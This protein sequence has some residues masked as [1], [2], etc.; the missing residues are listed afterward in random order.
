MEITVSEVAKKWGITR[1]TIYKKIKQ[2]K[3]SQ[4][5]SRKLD[6][7]EVVRVFGEPSVHDTKN[8][9]QRYT[10]ANTQK[11]GVL[12]SENA[13]L[14]ERIKALENAISDK[15]EALRKSEERE[16]NHFEQMKNLIEQIKLLQ[17]PTVA[18]KPQET[19]KK[20]FFGLFSR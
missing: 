13:V 20:G 6:V 3:I 9:D 16:Q 2:N 12:A 10:G 19:R 15:K 17:S 1:T 7:A 5:P 4:L 14:I 18:Q 8:S 11:I